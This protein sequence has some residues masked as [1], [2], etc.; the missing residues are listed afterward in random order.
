MQKIDCPSCGAEVPAVAYRCKHCFHDLKAEKKVNNGPLVFLGLLALMSIIGAGTLGA[1]VSFPT[2]E[3]I[4]V[5]EESKSIIFTRQYTV[6]SP[7]TERLPFTN[8]SNMEHV[9]QANGTYSVVAVLND[10]SRR[11]LA[12]AKRSQKGAT[13]KYARMMSKPWRE[14]DQTASFMK[15]AA[16]D[17]MKS[18]SNGQ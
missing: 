17:Q 15:R 13:E 1:I 5:D 2:S 10:G 9:I 16:E 11:D 12:T 18:Q 8:I 6:G 4:L 7:Q 14:I 3:N